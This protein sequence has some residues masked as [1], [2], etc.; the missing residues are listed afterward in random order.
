M[1]SHL[2]WPLIRF[3]LYEGNKPT[4]QYWLNYANNKEHLLG[5]GVW[6]HQT[7]DIMNSDDAQPVG[8]ST[9]FQIWILVKSRNPFRLDELKAKYSE[10]KKA[11]Q[12]YKQVC[13]SHNMVPRPSLIVEGDDAVTIP[14]APSPDSGVR[15]PPQ[16]PAPMAVGPSSN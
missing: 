3:I 5:E 15:V 4:S 13:R 8:P 10:V 1:E 14:A 12:L 11:Y 7:L 16:Q 2:Q 9:P 6:V